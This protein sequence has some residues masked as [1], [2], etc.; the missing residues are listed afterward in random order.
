MATR[1]HENLENAV[2]RTFTVKAAAAA[3]AN[4]LIKFGAADDEVEDAGANEAGFGIAIESAVAAAKVQV[5]LLCGASIIK[6]KVGT[7]GATRGAAAVNAA[8]GLT[9]QTVGGGTTLVHIA[10][11]FLQSGV[12]GDLVGLMPM[13]HSTVM[14]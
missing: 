4:R 2:I 14:A 1:A 7:G 6:V 11:Y 10:G 13:R 12:V 8:D 9:D 3:T 5:A